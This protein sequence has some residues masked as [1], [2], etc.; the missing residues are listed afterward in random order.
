ML[1]IVEMSCAH[2]SATLKLWSSDS[3]VLFAVPCYFKTVEQHSAV[4]FAQCLHKPFCTLPGS[5]I[6]VQSLVWPCVQTTPTCA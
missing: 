1:C 5:A 3:V 2:P 4:L 6:K